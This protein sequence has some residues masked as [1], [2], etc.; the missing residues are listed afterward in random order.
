MGADTVILNV[1]TVDYTDASGNQSFTAE[2]AASV[3]VTLVESALTISGRPTAADPGDTAGSPGV[4]TVASGATR[5]YLYALTANANGYDTY[6][7]T[8]GIDAGD[9][10]D[11][12]NQTITTDLMDPDGTNVSTANPTDVT[13]GASVIVGRV[14]AD[15]LIFPGGTLDNLV[16]NDIVVIN[17]VDYRVGA[18]TLGSG[19][20]HTY[21]D[22]ASHT[23]TGVLTAEVPG[24]LDLV[25]NPDGSNT[26]PNFNDTVIGM[27]VREQVLLRVQIYAEASVAGTDGIVDISV[28]IEPDGTAGSNTAQVQNVPTTFTGAGLLSIT[29]LVRNVTAGGALAATATG[30]SGDVLEYQVTVESGGGD[31]ANVVVTDAVP[32]YTTLV[33]SGS[34]FASYTSPGGPGTISTAVDDENSDEVSGANAGVAAGDSLTFYL[35]NAQDGSVGN[36]GTVYDGETFTIVYQVTID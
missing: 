23:D 3:T 6:D 5:D 16:A 25:A 11:V 28:V 31:A 29:K 35:G 24:Q 26:A 13:L 7:L 10:S 18:V 12:A 19:G 27:L 14:D 9:T 15:S 4:A 22:G 33:L 30:A 32:D 17:G 36:G 20:S 34:D 1:V 21:A 2:A 8:I